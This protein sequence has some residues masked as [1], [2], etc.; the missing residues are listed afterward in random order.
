MKINQIKQSFQLLYSLTQHFQFWEFTFQTLLCS[1]MKDMN[2]TGSKHYHH[3]RH[4]CHHH[5]HLHCCHSNISINII[6]A[7]ISINNIP[8]EAAL[9]NCIL[10]DAR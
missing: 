3:P 2:S 10:T 8:K 6:T 7:I 4:H 1:W 9:E 5:H